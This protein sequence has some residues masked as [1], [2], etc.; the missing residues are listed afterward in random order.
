MIKQRMWR[1]DWL[2]RDK[3]MR[4]EAVADKKRKW[5]REREARQ[6]IAVR[7]DPLIHSIKT[8]ILINKY[9]FIFVWSHLKDLGLYFNNYFDAQ[10]V[11]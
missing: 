8:T 9:S 2:S 4:A 5:C 11:R 1:K 6:K 10:K 7:I 3:Q